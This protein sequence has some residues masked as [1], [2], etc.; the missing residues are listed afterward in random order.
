MWKLSSALLLLAGICGLLSL[1]FLDHTWCDEFFYG[2]CQ[3]GSAAVLAI[4]GGASRSS[5]APGLAGF[6]LIMPR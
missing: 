3:M 2:T 4:L 5:L 6:L 1:L